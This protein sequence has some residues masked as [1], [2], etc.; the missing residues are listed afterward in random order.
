M[1]E[2]S[3]HFLCP[4]CHTFHDSLVRVSLNTSFQV[5]RVSD[6]YENVPELFLDSIVGQKCPTAGETVTESDPNTMVLVAAGRTTN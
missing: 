2:Y 1:T 4:N 6:V 5:R 3:L